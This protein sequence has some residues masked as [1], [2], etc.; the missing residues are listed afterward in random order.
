MTHK[1]LI[2]LKVAFKRDA[3]DGESVCLQTIN[4]SNICMFLFF[5]FASS[6]ISKEKP[7]YA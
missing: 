7:N 1:I 5:V 2:F 6:Y 4:G 3:K